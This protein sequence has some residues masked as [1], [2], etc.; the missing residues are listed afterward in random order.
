MKSEQTDSVQ[1]AYFDYQTGFPVRLEWF[2]KDQMG[3][4]YPTSERIEEYS[5]FETIPSKYLDTKRV[6][7]RKGPASIQLD[8]A[9]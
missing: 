9:N 5:C 2:N 1:F 3:N 6:E 7:I 4:P 8:I